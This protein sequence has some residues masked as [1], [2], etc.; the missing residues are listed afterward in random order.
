MKPYMKYDKREK[1]HRNHLLRQYATDH[2]NM[3]YT[4]L[5]NIFRITKQRVGVIIKKGERL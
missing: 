1:L 5:G 3:S 2:P 4:V